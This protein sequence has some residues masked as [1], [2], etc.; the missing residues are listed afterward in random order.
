MN[1]LYV[2][3]LDH[4]NYCY[5]SAK[6]NVLTEAHILIKYDGLYGVYEKILYSIMTLVQYVG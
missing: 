2:L 4:C 3:C 5:V 6:D 1:R